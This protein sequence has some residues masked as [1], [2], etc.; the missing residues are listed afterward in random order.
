MNIILLKY[1]EK[2]NDTIPEE[3][4]S[5]NYEWK[6]KKSHWD[7][8]AVSLHFQKTSRSDNLLLQEKTYLTYF[9]RQTGRNNE[10]Q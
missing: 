8:K 7:N 1:F 2:A 10:Y 9:K 3:H 6:E 4:L 5:H